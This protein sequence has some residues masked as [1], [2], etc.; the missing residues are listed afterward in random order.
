MFRPNISLK[1]DG[2]NYGLICK[3]ELIKHRLY[4]GDIENVYEK[5]LKRAI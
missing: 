1:E 5:K 2:K 3:Y 4:V